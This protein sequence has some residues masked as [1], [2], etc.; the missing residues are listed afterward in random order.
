MT[1]CL[2]IFILVCCAISGAS[3][4]VCDTLMFHFEESVFFKLDGTWWNPLYSWTNKYRGKLKK[5]GPAFFGSTTFLA[6]ITDA[7]H[8]FDTMRS[9]FAQ[10]PFVACFMA[11]VGWDWY[12]A[13]FVLCVVKL[14]TGAL[15][16]LFYSKIL[17]V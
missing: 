12:G 15:F 2:V 5:N 6:F 4:A 8:L 11:Y 7:W 16:E 13:I 1:L 17:K 9:T 3:K 10:L 14:V